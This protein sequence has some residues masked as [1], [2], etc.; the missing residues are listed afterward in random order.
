M[1]LLASCVGTSQRASA[2]GDPEAA[3]L[4]LELAHE[5]SQR[6][7]AESDFEVGP[8]LYLRTLLRK[9]PEL[10]QEGRQHSEV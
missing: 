7:K 10:S 3:R 4:A 5:K 8:L 2:D 9:L 6:L 1:S